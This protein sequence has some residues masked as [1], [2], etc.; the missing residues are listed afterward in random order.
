MEVVTPFGEVLRL[1]IPFPKALPVEPGP[2]YRVE[3]RCDYFRCNRLFPIAERG[4][5]LYCSDECAEKAKAQ[6]RKDR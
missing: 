1:K 6:R 2:Y 3:A 4:N 5:K